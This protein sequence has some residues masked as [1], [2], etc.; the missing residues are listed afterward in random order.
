[1]ETTL[2]TRPVHEGRLLADLLRKC[3]LLERHL[4]GAAGIPLE[5]L[6]CLCALQI[7]SPPS[8]KALSR[9]L[10]VH[11]TRASK[12]L[13]SLELKG[14]IAR[15]W[16][17]EDRRRELISLTPAGVRMVNVVYSLS[18]QMWDRVFAPGRE[19][20]LH[21]LEELVHDLSVPA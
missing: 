11:I 16:S 15:E 5:E 1:M 19:G 20:R 9:A 7:D 6:Y 8:V 10:G 4:A 12:I 21:G 3:H 13:H 18:A 14:Y 2:P 17:A